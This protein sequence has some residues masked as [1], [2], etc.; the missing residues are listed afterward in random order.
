MVSLDGSVSPAAKNPA[1]RAENQPAIRPLTPKGICV[2]PRLARPRERHD[3]RDED[4]IHQGRIPQLLLLRHY[5][6][7]LDE[8]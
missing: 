7:T 3:L 1:T 5:P 6:R 4:E 2:A 8:A